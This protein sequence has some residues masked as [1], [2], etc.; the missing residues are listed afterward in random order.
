MVYT[1]GLVCMYARLSVYLSDDTFREPRRSKFIFAHAAYLH[2]IRV[3]FI[4]KGHWVTVK[5]AG[6]KKVENS[7]SHNVKL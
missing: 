3:E 1:F 7:Y 6:A 2:Q 4:Y 5:V